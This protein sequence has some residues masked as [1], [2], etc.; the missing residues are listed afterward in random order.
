MLPCMKWWCVRYRMNDLLP[1]LVAHA[2]TTTDD[3][4]I[5]FSLNTY[6]YVYAILRHIVPSCVCVCVQTDFDISAVEYEVVYE[7]DTRFDKGKKDG[8]DSKPAQAKPEKDSA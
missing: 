1:S 5:A 4:C 8:G 7:N 2:N 3:F 6:T